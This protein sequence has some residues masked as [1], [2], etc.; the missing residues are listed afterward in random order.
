MML[1]EIAG[2]ILTP[3]KQIN[4]PLGDVMHGL[5]VSDPGFDGF[6]EVYFS[7]IHK[8]KIKGWKIHNKMTS[9]LIAIH[10]CIRFVII[11]IRN[12]SKTQGNIID[13]KLSPTNFYRLTIPPQVA[14][15]FRGLTEKNILCNV[16][17]MEHIPEEGMN[18]PLESLSYDW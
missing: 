15:S 4:H 7:L 6:G 11:D 3:L 13:I 18:L 10:G 5:K 14:Y 1:N 9:N 12:D 8:N 17:N 2:V 16:S